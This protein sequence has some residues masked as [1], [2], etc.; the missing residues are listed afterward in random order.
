MPEIMSLLPVPGARS[1]TL[2]CPETTATCPRHPANRLVPKAS[3]SERAKCKPTHPATLSTTL[4]HPLF[5]QSGGSCSSSYPLAP[6][7]APF[8]SLTYPCYSTPS[9]FI[10]LLLQIF[11][12]FQEPVYPLQ[13]QG[14]SPHSHMLYCDPYAQNVNEPPL[15]L[16]ADSNSHTEAQAGAHLGTGNCWQDVPANTSV[17]NGN[18]STWPGPWRPRSPEAVAHQ[19]LILTPG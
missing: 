5:L 10:C 8:F 18:Q 16:G 13:C 1:S 19:S 7:K 6:F 14:L 15:L 11:V 3:T 12:I 17:S 4:L 2:I 9:H